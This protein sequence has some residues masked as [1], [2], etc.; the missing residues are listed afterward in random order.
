[1]CSLEKEKLKEQFKAQALNRRA[2]KFGEALQLSVIQANPLVQKQ[3]IFECSEVL[4]EVL[5]AV[6]KGK[7]ALRLDFTPYKLYNLNKERVKRRQQP[8][9]EEDEQD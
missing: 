9:E 4:D 2:S 3:L 6:E 5:T 8:I 7:K 1:M